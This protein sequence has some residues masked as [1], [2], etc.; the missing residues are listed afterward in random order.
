VTDDPSFSAN[1]LTRRRF[2]VIGA[3]G[4]GA[5]VAAAS[6][7]SAAEAAAKVPKETVNYQMS[8]K[9]AARCGSCAY[10]QAPSSCNYVDGAISPSGWCMLYKAKG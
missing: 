8:P 10:F 2:L 1:E 9:G 6:L 3:Y 5:A 7:S 4:G